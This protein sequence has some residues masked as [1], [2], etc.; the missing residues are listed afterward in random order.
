MGS[1]CQG[2]TGIDTAETVEPLKKVKVDFSGQWASQSGYTNTIY[3]NKITWS[4]GEIS[5]F[6]LQNGKRLVTQLHNTQYGGE[7]TPDDRIIWSDGD[8][9]VR[10]QGKASGGGS[11]RDS[12]A[13]GALVGLNCCQ[14]E[15]V[16]TTSDHGKPRAAPAFD[17]PPE[18]PRRPPP[19][20]VM[21]HG[22]PNFS[23]S[24][25]CSAVEGDM[26]K[27]LLDNGV[28]YMLRTGA[29]AMSYGVGRARRIVVHKGDE[30]DTQVVGL[31]EFRQTFVVGKP[32]QRTDS[33]DGMVTI[34]PA[35]EG[36]VLRCHVVRDDG[37]KSEQ[38]H[39][40]DGEIYVVQ[41]ISPVGTVAKWLFER[42]AE[43]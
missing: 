39:M 23:G 28:N 17:G 8:V 29:Q 26:D 22:K 34:S 25:T 12:C 19:A 41:G 42:D 16:V 33:Q 15:D 13:L 9:W 43:S 7:L 1:A 21:K 2:P 4:T 38:R 11:T 32:N 27:F 37:S 3:D 20:S 31:K 24:W 40:F 14:D 35:W 18:A 5:N 36:D 6:D 10:Q 30:I